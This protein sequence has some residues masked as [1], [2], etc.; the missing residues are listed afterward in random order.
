MKSR[1]AFTLLEMLIVAS[2][3]ITIGTV[4]LFQLAGH[5]E[6]RLIEAE[7]KILEQLREEIVRTFDSEDFDA[8]NVLSVTGSMPTGGTVSRFSEH[9]LSGTLGAVA[10]SD[11]FA[12]VARN[13]G[14]AVAT[15]SAPD[16][17]SQPELYKIAYNSYRRPRALF[18]G[19]AE[20]DKQRFVLV[21]L[22]AREEQFAFPAYESGATWFDALFNTNW[23]TQQRTTPAA[24]SSRLTADQVA[25][26]NGTSSAGSNLWR[27]RVLTF[28]VSKLPL[29]MSNGHP[30]DSLIV[31]TD[32]GGTTYTI[33]PGASATQSVFAG[34]TVRVFQG[35]TSNPAA[36]T[37]I[38]RK[39]SDVI[40]E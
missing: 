16:A 23:N 40:I 37:F 6:R 24:W 2:I 10:A 39:A 20:A 14:L 32:A 27:L 12:K 4:L 18:A 35:S 8:V 1:R 21:S 15:G 25:A 30:T 9:N 22:M 26:W 29:H 17:A 34:R 38:L 33:A 31:T 28:T 3:A 36:R 13:R 5:A 7:D 11:W 19:P